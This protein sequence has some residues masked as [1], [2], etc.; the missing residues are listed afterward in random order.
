MRLEK[1]NSDLQFVKHG[2]PLG[3]HG[4]GPRPHDASAGALVWVLP[5]HTG[6]D[7]DPRVCIVAVTPEKSSASVGAKGAPQPPGDLDGL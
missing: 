1:P 6:Q 7:A 5:D 4:A 2:P 3:R